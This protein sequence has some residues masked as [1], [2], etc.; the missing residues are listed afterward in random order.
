[1]ASL[2]N[3]APPQPHQRP[4]PLTPGVPMERNVSGS[5]AV[6]SNSSTT[7]SGVT[8]TVDPQPHQHP[9]AKNR[10]P[11]INSVTSHGRSLNRIM[12]GNVRRQS[13]MSGFSTMSE[14]SLPWTTKDMGFNA[15]S[16]VLNDPAQRTNAALKPTKNDIPPVPHV[17][18]R[19]IKPSEFDQYLKHIAPVFDRYN[20]NKLIGTEGTP[21]LD[22]PNDSP[23]ASVLNLIDSDPSSH[24]SPDFPAH[25][26]ESSRNPY[27]IPASPIL[28][29]V[30]TAIPDRPRRKVSE[31]DPPMIENVPT[32]FFDPEFNLENPRTFDTV[33]EGADI[34]GNSGP[35]PPVATNSILQEKLSHYLDTV[36]VHLIQEISRRS[37]SFFEALSNLQALHQET[38]DCVAQIHSIRQ[39]MKRIHKSQ[40]R[41]GL[42]VV[43]LKRRR[44]N[45]GQLYNGIK[46]VQEI[47]SSQPMIQI[48][49]GQGDYFAA[50]DLIDEAN[51][52][53]QGG[54]GGPPGAPPSHD[55]RADP[56]ASIDS[57]QS[58]DVY[59]HPFT[60]DPRQSLDGRP[61]FDSR[62]S[63][64][65]YDPSLDHALVPRSPAPL[66][67]P[68]PSKQGFQLPP[69]DLRAVRALLNFSSQLNEMYRAIGVMMQHDLVTV[70]LAELQRGLETMDVAA[71]V[72]ELM[73]HS[74]EASVQAQMAKRDTHHVKRTVTVEDV[75]AEE[76]L[77]ER[78][79]PS[80][81][82][83]VRTGKLGPTLQA[84]RERLMVEVKELIRQVAIS[85]IDGDAD[86]G[87]ARRAS[88]GGFIPEG[89]EV[90]RPFLSRPP[91][92]LEMHRVPIAP[93]SFFP[94]F[95]PSSKLS[96]QLR[97]MTF[98]SFSKMLVS[99]YAVLLD[100]MKR[101]AIYHE[102][103]VTIMIDA[104]RHPTESVSV[105]TPSADTDDAP[106]YAATLPLVS[107]T[108]AYHS[109]VTE[110]AEIVFAVADLAHVRCAKL[111][112][113]R[114]DQNAQLNPTDFYRLFGVT[115]KFVVE[116]EGL[117]GRTCYGLRG[118]IMSQAKSFLNHF[119]ME[120]MKQQ[121]LLIEN[122]QWIQAG[123]PIDFQRIVDRIIAFAKS[124]G[125]DFEDPPPTAAA[126]A[127]MQVVDVLSPIPIRAGTMDSIGSTNA[128]GVEDVRSGASSPTVGGAG[129][130]IMA[131]NDSNRFLVVNGQSFFMVGCGL[132]LVKMLDDYLRCMA[133]IPS[134]TTDVMQKMMELLTLFN[135]RVCGVILGA[136]AMQSAGLKTI[137]A[138]HLGKRL[139][140]FHGP[141]S[142]QLSLSWIVSR[143]HVTFFLQSSSRVTVHW[144]DD[145]VEPGARGLRPQGPPGRGV[146]EAGVH[147]ERSTGDALQRV[148]VHQLGSTG[149][150][151][152][153]PQLVHGRSRQRNHY[154]A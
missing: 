118:T 51:R 4:S 50:L 84:Y 15:I 48:L 5:S 139:D 75:R 125:V 43:R 78:I 97:S 55:H 129:V 57:R 91:S 154:P 46:M 12:H 2:K 27:G 88:R 23:Y 24:L 53:L 41:Q 110:S 150:E 13:T 58:L 89:A 87:G 152:Q 138:K 140:Q 119:H 54:T 123:V 141:R 37:N 22:S 19:K 128:A 34:I 16:G 107:T 120:K 6:S 85:V 101:I 115:W 28:P 14:T 96:K 92:S 25:R 30:S 108:A 148:A 134:L 102:L 133:N 74:R 31:K 70:L 65:G 52:V 147:H 142:K 103:L 8:V 90:R 20:Y 71:A 66:P 72:G 73:A 105:P 76:K 17:P 127:P 60:Q 7:D 56:R 9:P 83:L 68:S 93:H 81:M 49:L 33:C 36:E 151:R 3:L 10:P 100:A 126:S 39:K 1:M 45:V 114:A 106:T 61:S 42:E 153:S 77:R 117:C 143:F 21:R 122:E 40:V 80:V 145:R 130:E 35:N 11:S 38:L 26:R 47:R 131:E 82:G 132:L 67:S 79:A 64:D 95:F 121:T 69:L 146:R 113:V 62:R 59:Y 32:I 136:G 29:A 124:E 99:I 111:V 86:R 112:G 137:S 44:Q 144:Y 94:L 135:S 63:L 116:G 109:L 104:D 18:I 98:D 149:A